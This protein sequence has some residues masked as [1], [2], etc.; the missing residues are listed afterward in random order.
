MCNTHFNLQISELKLKVR[1]A[2]V[3]AVYKHVINVSTVEL[4]KFNTGEV[5]NYMSTD[6]DRVVNFAPSLHA[7][8]SLPFQLIVTIVLLYQQL[9]VSSL[10]GV[11]ITI[12]V[13]PLNKFIADKIGSMSTKMMEAKDNRVQNMAELLSGNFHFS[14]LTSNI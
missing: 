10:T 2:I 8:W 6:T 1:A 3:T 13:I 14:N 12:L 4:N 5:L 11:G 7:I 9:G